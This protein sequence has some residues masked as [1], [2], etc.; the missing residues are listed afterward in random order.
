MR[1]KILAV[2]VVIGGLSSISPDFAEG[3]AGLKSEQLGRFQSFV[4][5]QAHPSY[6]FS[7]T[8]VVGAVLPA[9]GVT[10]YT[11]PADYSVPQYRYTVVNNQTVLVDPG[12]RKVIQIVP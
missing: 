12:T 4:A 7:G 11:V 8:L 5:S 1:N 10:Y 3:E 6:A 2:A 9:E